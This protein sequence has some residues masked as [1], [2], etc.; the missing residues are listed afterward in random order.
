MLRRR[1]IQKKRCLWR[2]YWWYSKNFEDPKFTNKDNC[3]KAINET[4]NKSY[5][6]DTFDAFIVGLKESSK[7]EGV[8]FE[9]LDIVCDSSNFLKFGL[10]S[11]F[12]VL[13]I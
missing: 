5:K 6:S 9:K 2:N 13:L 1:I 8:E 11:L 3:F 10:I 7:K 4:L 12:S